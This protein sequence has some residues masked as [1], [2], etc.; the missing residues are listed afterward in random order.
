VGNQENR[1]LTASR[2]AEL[3]RGVEEGEIP[4]IVKELNGGYAAND[5]PYRVERDG[6]GYKLAL[7]EKYHGLRNRFHGRVRQTRLSQAAIDVLALVAYK[8]PLTG[9][10]VSRLRDKPS[11]HVLSQLVRRGLL[12]IERKKTKRRTAQYFTTDRFL[13]LFDMQS[14]EDLPLSEELDRQ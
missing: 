4:A 10:E 8:Q 2:A 11:S 7:T 3:M 5:C 9:D 12:R 14:L 13:E 1:P 6:G